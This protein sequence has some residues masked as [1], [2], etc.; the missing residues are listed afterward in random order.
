MRWTRSKLHT[1]AWGCLEHRWLEQRSEHTTGSLS[2]RP[3]QVLPPKFAQTQAL[4]TTIFNVGD[5]HISTHNHV[6]G[7]LWHCEQARRLVIPSTLDE[8]QELQILTSSRSELCQ[9]T[10]MILS[11][12]Q[13]SRC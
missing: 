5:A 2:G 9:R 12:C 6:Q 4:P 1:T 11:L 8:A 7:R 13:F 10:M 3:L